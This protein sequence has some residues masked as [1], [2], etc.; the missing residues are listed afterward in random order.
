MELQLE[1]NQIASG[2]V[3]RVSGLQ[4]NGIHCI[5]CVRTIE[6]LPKTLQGLISARVN[7]SRGM[8]DLE[9]Q[10]Q[11]ISF[12]EI[13]DE[14]NDLGYQLVKD[15]QIATANLRSKEDR[16]FLYRLGVAGFGTMNT[17]MLAVSLFQGFYTGIDSDVA[18]GFRWISLLL[19]L[20]VVT[21]SA[22]PFYKNSVT[23][24]KNRTIHIDLPLSLAIV[25]AFLLS[26]WNTILSEPY[27]YFDSV[28]ALI[29]LLLCG[30]WVQSKALMRARRDTDIS[31]SLLPTHARRLVVEKEELVD[32]TALSIGDI[33]RVLPLER[34][35]V[36]GRITEGRSA[37]DN[38]VLTGESRPQA[39]EVGDFV[40]AGTL[41]I[42]APIILEVTEVG[43]ATRVGKILS[44]LDKQEKPTWGISAFVDRASAWFTLVVIIFAGVGFVCWLPD[45]LEKALQVAVTFLIVTCP[46]ALG[47]AT[48]LAVG[49]T[50]GRASKRSIF[51]KSAESL[52]W[53]KQCKEI[54]FDK[55]GTLTEG[56]LTVK[57]SWFFNVNLKEEILKL[58]VFD[59]PH[60]AAMA[61]NDFALKILGKLQDKK[62]ETKVVPSRGTEIY[63]NQYLVGYLG[64]KKWL[65]ELGVL[66][67]ES[68]FELSA[69]QE[70][71]SALYFADHSKKLI[72][73]FVLGDV[74][75][76]NACEVISKL[77]GEGR[78]ISIL[79]GDDVTSVRAVGQTLGLPA[80]V[81]FG[82]L[83]AQ[84][85]AEIVSCSSNSCYIGDGVNDSIAMKAAGVSIG[86]SGGL[87]ASL[88]VAD[89]FIASGDITDVYDLFVAA[90]R[91]MK[92][93]HRNLIFS[94]FYNLIGGTLAL[95][96][97]MNPLIA[98]LLMPTSSL[99]VVVHTLI[100]STFPETATKEIK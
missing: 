26:C 49:V 8:I 38:A 82:E 77:R 98:A 19:T 14:I 55:T 43:G 23:G 2:E 52:E 51:I 87:K 85:K 18:E 94:V 35:P 63:L 6:N 96:G 61:V 28:C 3:Q 15:P 56:R 42:E 41:N 76:T 5:G 68:P 1:E 91:L 72:A 17:M 44:S 30:R 29:F 34:I 16:I 90:D 9:Y 58:L 13:T 20:P 86:V 70:I 59:S 46:C 79:S 40:A 11:V 50:L 89:I 66:F 27:V 88:E 92:I 33:I 12:E 99:T 83:S 25:S 22:L 65:A 69:K 10:P 4:I 24:L 93:I 74:V 64:S 47:I 71:G 53:I 21:F 32:I 60:P 84:Q 57:D 73:G 7:L 48:P 54:Y 37:I 80:D 36:D 78:S 39:V 95:T 67:V 97:E 45:G 81:S 31:W 75:K 100:S 62:V